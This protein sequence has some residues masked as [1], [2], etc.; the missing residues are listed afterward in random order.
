MKKK[1]FWSKT[2]S[3]MTLGDGLKWLIVVYALIIA[4]SATFCVIIFRIENILDWLAETKRRIQSKFTRKQWI[5]SK[6]E[7]PEE[8][9]WEDPCEEDLTEEPY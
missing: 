4:F 5:T 7:E 8:E 6:K 3:E 1:G 2:Q 9:D